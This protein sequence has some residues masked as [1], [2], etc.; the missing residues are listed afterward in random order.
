MFVKIKKILY[1]KVNSL[2]YGIFCAFRDGS[3][4]RS[5]NISNHNFFTNDIDG[6]PDYSG[7]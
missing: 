7:F 5:P 4:L 6:K 2:C 1:K 3:R